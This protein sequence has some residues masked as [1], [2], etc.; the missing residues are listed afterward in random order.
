MVNE[1]KDTCVRCGQEG[2]WSFVRVW[3]SVAEWVCVEWYE[4]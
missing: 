2:H 3:V 1:K 4:K